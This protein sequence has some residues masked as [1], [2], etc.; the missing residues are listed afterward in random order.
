MDGRAPVLALEAF[1][2]IVPLFVV[3]GA[4]LVVGAALLVAA[5]VS[6]ANAVLVVALL[7]NGAALVL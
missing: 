2:P 1:F 7:F 5:V 3:P 6:R 4:I